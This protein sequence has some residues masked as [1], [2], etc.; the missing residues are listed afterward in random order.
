M[1]IKARPSSEVFTYL[2]DAFAWLGLR[3]QRP[4]AA[5][6]AVGASE[7]LRARLGLK[8]W[9]MAAMQVGLLTQLADS[10]TDPEAQAAR[11]SGR[12]LN[13][14]VALDLMRNELIGADQPLAVT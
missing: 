8:M 6:T 2:L 11:R 10:V 9:P 3:R 14:S 1:T 7:G 4:I 12:Q 5:M 13:P